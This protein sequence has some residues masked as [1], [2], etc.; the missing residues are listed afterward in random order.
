[1]LNLQKTYFPDSICYGC[2]PANADG[3]Q[4][5]SLVDGDKTI[6]TWQAQAKHQAYPGIVNGGVIGTLLDC[7][8]NISA[9]WF[10]QQHNQ[11]ERPPMTV[12]AQYEIKLLAPTPPE[13]PLQLTAWVE[14]IEGKKIWMRG[15]LKAD[16]QLT[17][18]CQGLFIA[19]E[20]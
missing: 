7:H 2:G 12:T 17:A 4:L 3:L 20:N 18:T 6:A 16:E 1:M 15:E 10:Y 19:K 14:K 11:L 9:A 13:Q 5:E 8:C